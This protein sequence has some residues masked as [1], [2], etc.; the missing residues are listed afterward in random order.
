[1]KDSKIA[2]NAKHLNG[3][4]TNMTKPTQAN[5][6]LLSLP[7]FWFATLS[8]LFVGV[9][10]MLII[11]HYDNLEFAVWT[12]QNIATAYE[13]FK[14]PLVIASLAFPL[15]AVAIASHRSAQTLMMADLQSSQNRF[16][17]YY[18][19]LDKFK[20]AMEHSELNRWAY[21]LKTTHDNL[22]P[23][24]LN[25]GVLD[26]DTDTL[27]DLEHLLILLR[28]LV[29]S[30][31]SISDFTSVTEFGGPILDDELMSLK[32]G[33]YRGLQDAIDDGVVPD[34][35]AFIALSVARIL[36]GVT[37]KLKLKDH[38]PLDGRSMDDHLKLTVGILNDIKN[39]CG[40]TDFITFDESI[41]ALLFTLPDYSPI[42]EK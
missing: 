41:G 38:P 2:T 17:N 35:K 24:L 7:S 40:R 28:E 15:G 20:E 22:Y 19:H 13:H 14:V 39:Y 6:H 18:L 27:D 29:N 4:M 16:A 10:L 1:M 23:K 12:S 32:K 9:T 42:S 11:K 21:S 30:E 26:A 3:D 8:P 36:N 31:I 25:D 5:K 37:D 33:L 34:D